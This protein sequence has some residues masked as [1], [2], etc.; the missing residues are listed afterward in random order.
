MRYLLLVLVCNFSFGQNT[1]ET[2]SVVID[3]INYFIQK[4][5]SSEIEQRQYFIK[6]DGE[7]IKK[8]TIEIYHDPLPYSSFF[9][10]ELNGELGFFQ[11]YYPMTSNNEVDRNTSQDSMMIESSLNKLISKKITFNQL[12]SKL[13]ARA[14]GGIK[15]ASKT[16]DCSEKVLAYANGTYG[17]NGAEKYEGERAFKMK[18]GNYRVYMRQLRKGFNSSYSNS[19]AVIISV[20]DKCKVV[21]AKKSKKLR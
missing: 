18:D 9:I 17:Y 13:Y 7:I 10:K 19:F 5:M 8:Y 15:K 14:H 11:V 12:E 1:F 6:K 4:S 21:G 2:D 16:Q 3:K 20:N